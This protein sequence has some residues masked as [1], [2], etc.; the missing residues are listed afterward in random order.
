MGFAIWT[1][2]DEIREGFGQVVTFAQNLYE[3]VQ[4]WLTDKLGAVFDGIK[5]K[6]DAVTGFF[7]DMKDRLVGNSIVPDMVNGI[8]S[9]FGRMSTGMITSSGTAAAGVIDVFSSVLSPAAFTGIFTSAFTG[10]GG[11]IDSLKG[12]GVQLVSAVAEHFLAPL[13]D[14]I[15]GGI[16]AIFNGGG[17]DFIGPPAPGGGGGGAMG[18]IGILAMIPGWGWAAAGIAAAVAF[19]FAFTNKLAGLPALVG[20]VAHDILR[21]QQSGELPS[22]PGDPMSGRAAGGPVSAGRPYMV[23]E[24]GPEMFVPSSSGMILPN[25]IAKAIGA[26]VAR[27]LQA[28]PLTAVVPPD[29]VTDAVLYRMD[30]RSSIRQFRANTV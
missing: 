2:R 20:T 1:F 24:R 6:V 16:S 10:G 29:E 9:E 22:D 15:F 13:A 28:H 14:A 4:S 5:A 23:G 11:V 3:G 12:I 8:R 21:D 17:S 30:E 26:E 19:M 7:G 18:A 25:N 27:A